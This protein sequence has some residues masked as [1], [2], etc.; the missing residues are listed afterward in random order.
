MTRNQIEYQKTVEEKRSNLAR[1]AEAS[2]SNRAQEALTAARDAETARSN[3]ARELETNRANT[4]REAEENRSN[5]AR[6]LETNRHN[7]Q[8]E[9]ITREGNYLD[10]AGKVYSADSSKEASK[11]SADQAY[12][13]RVDSSYINKYGVDPTTIGNI[14]DYAKDAGKQSGKYTAA[15]IVAVDTGVSNLAKTIQQVVGGR[16]NV[17]TTNKQSQQTQSRIQGKQQPGKGTTAGKTKTKR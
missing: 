3:L 4:A 12:Q 8:Q 10:L 15:G 1:E 5:L 7:V 2:R 16:N 14:V 6:E 17:K 9:Q 13:A 11:Y